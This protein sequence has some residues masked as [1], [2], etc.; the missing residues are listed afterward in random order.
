[1]EGLVFSEGE[2]KIEFLFLND[3]QKS[4]GVYIFPLHRH[5]D[6]LEVSLICSG[7]ETIE[8]RRGEYTA[9]AGDIIIKNAGRIHQ[10][11]ATDVND[12]VELS[13]GV[14]GVQVPGLPP[15]TMIAQDIVPVIHAPEVMGVLRELFLF[16]Q[17]QH[18]EDG[19]EEESVQLAL[20]TFLSIVLT[21]TREHGVRMKVGSAIVPTRQ[22]SEVMEYIDKNFQNQ[23]SLNDVAKTFFVSPYYLAHQFKSEI[24]YTVNQYIQLRRMGMAE[25]R[26]AF[27]D[28]PIKTIATECGYTSL[29]YFYSVFKSKTGHT[30]SEF[31]SLIRSKEPSE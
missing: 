17:R 31:R 30:P 28:T 27:E 25:Q 1:M 4:T 29:K 11:T 12:L 20:R 6:F 21:A 15:N 14:S 26:L 3:I 19:E 10:E 5:D 2:L 18:R 22:I 9:A 24:G 8:Y 16:I 23:I 7:T 13:M